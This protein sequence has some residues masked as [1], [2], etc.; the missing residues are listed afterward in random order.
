M[1]R[2]MDLKAK[3]AEDVV[4]HDVLLLVAQDAG[5]HEGIDVHI[6]HD[7]QLPLPVPQ[8]LYLICKSLHPA[9]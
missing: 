3:Q 9:R 7:A 8:L 4:G 5:L 1:G 2:E 6:W